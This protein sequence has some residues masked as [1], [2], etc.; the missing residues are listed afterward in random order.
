MYLARL[1][2]YLWPITTYR[3]YHYI[4]QIYYQMQAFHRPTTTNLNLTHHQI[5]YHSL[6]KTHGC[7]GSTPRRLRLHIHTPMLPTVRHS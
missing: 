5:N 6:V 7:L 3:C 1:A 2:Y 4:H